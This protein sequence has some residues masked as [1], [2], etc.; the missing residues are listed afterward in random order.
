MLGWRY[1]A[2]SALAR[3]AGCGARGVLAE[4]R[5]GWMQAMQA[6]REDLEELEWAME[7]GDK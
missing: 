5:C 6:M 3:T 7:P 2:E 1:E 4:R